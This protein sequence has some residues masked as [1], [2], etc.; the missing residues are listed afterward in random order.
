[1]NSFKT[2]KNNQEVLLSKNSHQVMMEWEKPYMEACIDALNP[3]GDVLEIGFGCGYSATQIMK[4]APKSYTVVECDPIVIEKAK[5][6]AEEWA[7]KYPDMAI[8]IK[9]GTWQ[10]V[11][12]TLS[13]FDEIFFD[14]FPIEINDDSSDMDRA[15]SSKRFSVFLAICIQSHTKIG[16]KISMYINGI[17]DPILGSDSAPFV[18]LSTTYMDIFIP[19]TCKYRDV[20]YQKCLIPLIKIIKNYSFEESQQYAISEILKSIKE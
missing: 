11:L 8:M 20:K 9:E 12:P 2:D 19:N 6:W 7:K 17:I 18:E 14:D 3:K 1:M 5:V 15:I 16:S 4:F 10:S 13:I